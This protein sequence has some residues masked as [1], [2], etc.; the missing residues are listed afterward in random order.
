MIAIKIQCGCGQKYAFDTEPV[1]GRMSYTIACPVCGADGHR[2]RKHG[3]R[4]SVRLSQ[5]WQSLAVCRFNRLRCPP[6]R[7]SSNRLRR[8]PQRRSTGPLHLQWKPLS[9]P[10]GV[11]ASRIP[12]TLHPDAGANSK[13]SG[14]GRSPCQNLLGDAQEEVVKFMM[15]H[16]FTY[17]EATPTSNRPCSKNVVSPSARTALRRSGPVCSWFACP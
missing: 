6:Q 4:S 5:P 15:I 11:P 13:A 2:R 7:R 3:H 9:A 1:D 12:K 17:A 16:N 14:R 8:P 10:S